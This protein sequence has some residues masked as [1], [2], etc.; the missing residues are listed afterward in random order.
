MDTRQLRCKSWMTQERFAKRHCL[1][2]DAEQRMD[3]IPTLSVPMAR[4]EI[5]R[6][7]KERGLAEITAQV[8]DENKEVY[9]I[10][11][12]GMHA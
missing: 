9:E 8:M 10:H 2:K 4:R 3:N 6:I 7:A 11:V 5:E 1:D 12:V